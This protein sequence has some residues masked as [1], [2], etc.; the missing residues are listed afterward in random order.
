MGGADDLVVEQA[1]Q[2]ALVG[3]R[4]DPG[5]RVGG[6]LLGPSDATA[7]VTAPPQER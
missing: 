7:G 3:V 6:L 1:D 2:Q 5:D 4:G